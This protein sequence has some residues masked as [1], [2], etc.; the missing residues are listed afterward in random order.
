MSPRLN[1]NQNGRYY[2]VLDNETIVKT[3]RLYRIAVL[4]ILTGFTFGSGLVF[5][6]RS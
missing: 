5:F 4:S 3:N 6:L 2:L 1:D